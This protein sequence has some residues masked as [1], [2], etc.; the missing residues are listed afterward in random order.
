[1]KKILIYMFVLLLFSIQAGAQELQV[2]GKVTSSDGL[3]LPGVTVLQKGTQRGVTTD[4]TGEYAISLPAGAVLRFSFIGFKS[5][6]IHVGQRTRVNV[7]M[8]EE[9][10]EIDEVIV[11]AYGTAK[12]ESFTG[13]IATIKEEKLALRQVS[14]VTSALSGQLPGV[15]VR[16]GNGQPGV[17]SAVR[18]RGIGSL[19]AGNAPLYVVDGVPYDGDISS[20]NS[21]DIE[22]INV[23][24]DAASN[25]LYGARGA[26]GVILITTKRAKTAD[27]LIS[28]EARW[29]SNSRAVPNYRVLK[30]PGVYL[31]KVYEAMYNGFAASM[32]AANAHLAVLRDIATN[33][34]GGVGY[35]VHSV[36]A[37]EDLFDASGKLNPN[38]TLGY[39]DGQYTYLPDDWYK[40]LF[41]S[42]NLRQEYNVSVS[43]LTDKLNYYLSLGYLDDSGIMAGSGFKRY[44]S[45]A[46]VD[47]QAKE[48]LKV[49]SRVA[50]TRYDMQY[51]PDQT[52]SGSSGNLFFLANNIA[53]VY[54]LYARDDKGN[55][56]TD[57]HGFTVYDFGDQSSTNFKRTFMSGSNPASLSKLDKR[58]YAADVFSG[59]WFAAVEFMKGLTF[60]YNF[61]ADIDN[62]RY[63]RLYNAYY[64]Q[65]SKPG[66]VT[67]V[68]H[69]R[70]A[71][72][73]HQQLLSYT[74][75]FRDLH[76]LDVLLGHESYALELKGLQGSKEKLYDPGIVEIDNGILS[77]T[78]SSSTNRYKTEG[79]F[80]RAQYEFDR[81][82]IISV[83]YRR[84]ASSRFHKSKRWGN[85]GSVGG[86]WVA[87]RE[88]FL[89]GQTWIDFLKV[90]ASYG[91]Q[92]ND[93]L[94]YPGG[95]KNYYPDRDQYSLSENNGDFALNLIYKGNKEITWETSHSINAGIDFSLWN[96]K[97]SGTLEYFSRLTD[98][99]LYYRPVSLSGGYAS[100]PSNIG[101]VS[102][103]GLEV[104]LNS[105][106]VTTEKVRL[107][108]FANATMLKNKIKA[109]APELQGELIDGANIFQT[110][111]S[112]YQLYF[113]RYAG[114]DADGKALYH[115]EDKTT[116]THGTTT[117]WPQATKRATG[118][119]LPDLYGGFGFTLEAYGFD[120]SFSAAYQLGGKIFDSGYQGLMHAG[121]VASAGHNWHRD[122]LG[123]WSPANATSSIPR[124]GAND[125]YA[126]ATSDRFLISSNYLDITN[127]SLGYT[128]PA[129]FLEQIV[130]LRVYCVA[131]NV[132]LFAKR[133][134]LDPRQS[135]T[136][137]NAA[138]YTP[139]RTVSGGLSFK[140]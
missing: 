81:S 118:D 70:T 19:S 80:G 6:E 102:N 105:S 76:V 73:N 55:I 112:I 67:Y 32:T 39:N 34:N 107:A 72:I 20:I 78:A 18:I 116:G 65:Y 2:S 49:G 85:F 10:H 51:P 91:I 84:D 13:S 120:L 26:N 48:W 16:S 79:W 7:R 8:E 31:E 22:S 115:V 133:R 122:I 94:L 121:S 41:D 24:K 114:V 139:I 30:D 75:T 117:E 137:V 50:Y 127:I 59:R 136:A 14:N 126:S 90:K 124:V 140:F 43:G 53:P 69:S 23:L 44:S 135:Y 132:A 95:G 134:G 129:S 21:A 36:P 103:S 88:P 92:G 58:E 37:G 111:K 74:A 104:G 68:G 71:S 35:R 86:A 106:L 33:N 9:V 12:K 60:T 138:R 119:L 113:P 5:Q 101:K 45:R 4:A 109:L 100:I 46:N 57:K 47:Y 17:T 82:Y 40:E 28:V 98:D 89:A 29:G 42:G 130:D 66:G 1:M 11:V 25:A 77:P 61:G 54:P 110:G 27:A 62:T 123:S 93:D 56:M 3:A 83:S 96:G 108:L 15:Q 38:A 64:G 87:S 97:L 128:L 52:S 63:S 125:T 99:M 131:D